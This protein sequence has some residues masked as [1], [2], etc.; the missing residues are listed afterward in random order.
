[1]L[2]TAVNLIR[3]RGGL[4]TPGLALTFHMTEG[5]LDRTLAPLCTP[6]G[7]LISCDVEVAGKR[8]KEY[9]ASTIGGG[10]LKEIG[11]SGAARAQ[12]KKTGE[13]FGDRTEITQALNARFTPPPR[14][15]ER[16]QSPE[17]ATKPAPAQPSR[18]EISHPMTTADSIL[19]ALKKHGP[20]TTAQL[21]G[22]VDYKFLST[23]TS[24]L[25]RKGRIVKLGG[26]TK[27]A[28]YGLKGQKAPAGAAA[29]PKRAVRKVP[30]NRATGKLAIGL[31]EA[32]MRELMASALRG[33]GFQL[34]AEETRSVALA[35]VGQGDEA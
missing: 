23:V 5:E 19:Q 8:V 28:V 6:G 27:S 32:R 2:D 31:T 35:A 22:H 17:P 10:K 30:L 21:R 29:A 13:P 7:P 18:K 3:D 14:Q 25:A 16:V 9:R 34:S 1:M 4:R 33:S 15:N 26:G 12:P 20:M 11:Y 24:Q